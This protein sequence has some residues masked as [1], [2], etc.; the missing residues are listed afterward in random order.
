M[1]YRRVTGTFLKGYAD[2]GNPDGVPWADKVIK[3]KLKGENYTASAFYPKGEIQCKLSDEGQI[4]G[5]DGQSGTPLGILLWCEDEGFNSTTWVLAGPDDF[6]WEFNLQIGDGSTIDLA[7]IRAAGTTPLTPD[8]PAYIAMQAL[9]ADHAAKSDGSAHTISGVNGLQSALDTLQGNID[10]EQAS[11]E[12]V[13]ATLSATLTQTNISLGSKVGFV[14][15]V[16]NEDA[17]FML[18]EFTSL[19]TYCM[20]RQTDNGHIYLTP[21]S[22]GS[23]VDLGPAV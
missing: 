20:V 16:A 17:R 23:W 4:R 22:G 8:T 1:A 6:E 7:T 9:I 3:F 21:N 12:G 5:I 13:E 15:D 18:Q 2:S 19:P 14:S 11:R 10:N